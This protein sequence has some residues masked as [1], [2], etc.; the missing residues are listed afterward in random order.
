LAVEIDRA[1]RRMTLRTPCTGV[2]GLLFKAA[3]I[4]LPANIQEA[5]IS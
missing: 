1:G 2:A 3:H 5:R 4:A